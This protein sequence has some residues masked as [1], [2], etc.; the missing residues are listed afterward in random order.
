MINVTRFVDQTTQSIPIQEKGVVFSTTG[1]METP[2]SDLLCQYAFRTLI[3]AFKAPREGV[4]V[5]AV[6]LERP[7]AIQPSSR[8]STNSL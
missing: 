3:P 2:E 7:D 5:F 4:H 1:I 8:L 6:G